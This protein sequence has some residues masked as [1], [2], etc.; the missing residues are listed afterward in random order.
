MEQ[1]FGSTHCHMERLDGDVVRQ[2]LFF[3]CGSG[4][5]EGDGSPRWWPASTVTWARPDEAAAIAAADAAAAGAA[6]SAR[7][8]AG[9]LSLCW[10]RLPLGM[11]VAVATA[12]Q[13]KD[14]V[15][16]F[17]QQRNH[18]SFVDFVSVR[19]L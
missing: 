4:E 14:I 5:Y 12:A 19:E 1:N 8:Y 17:R 13:S 11:G 18:N 16:F 7:G 10:F 2:F 9:R 15:C 3:T 6:P